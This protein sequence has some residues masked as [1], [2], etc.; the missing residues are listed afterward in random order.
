MAFSPF[1]TKARPTPL[2]S[3]AVGQTYTRLHA[4]S[5]PGERTHYSVWIQRP[6][7]LEGH[8]RLMCQGAEVA[9][10][11]A[12]KVVGSEKPLKLGDVR[13]L[14]SFTK[15]SPGAAGDPLTEIIPRTSGGH[16]RG[17]RP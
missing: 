4:E 17:M 9:I 5:K 16:K 7:P 1:Q 11:G 10:G 8:D 6:R 14:I 15:G 13:A 3:H 2:A 12:G